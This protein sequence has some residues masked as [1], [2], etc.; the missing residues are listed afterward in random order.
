MA[1]KVEEIMVV[2]PE[3]T[4]FM[5][6]KAEKDLV[7]LVTCTPFGI[8]SHRLVVTGRRVYYKEKE[9]KKIKHS[10]LLYGIIVTVFPSYLWSV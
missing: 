4:A 7:S 8:N 6:I 10:F 9:Y 1:Y 2:K 5:E 3:D